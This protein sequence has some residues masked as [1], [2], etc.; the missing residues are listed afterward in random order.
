MNKAL[1][2][3]RISNDLEL[4]HTQSNNAVCK[5]NI[6]INRVGVEGTDFINVVVWNKQAEN[7]VKYQKKG[8]LISVE[9]TIRVDKY[10]NEAGENRYNTYILANSIQ[11]LSSKSDTQSGQQSTTQSTIEDNKAAAEEFVSDP[12]ADFGEQMQITDDDLPF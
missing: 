12:Y 1:L 8:S 11:Y 5:F 10:Q 4:R 7:L 2:V 3:G 6:A 9:G